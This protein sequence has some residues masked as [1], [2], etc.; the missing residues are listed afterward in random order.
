VPVA[1][2]P[3]PAAPALGTSFGECK[4]QFGNQTW[5]KL[6]LFSGQSY[7]TMKPLGEKKWPLLVS[8]SAAQAARNGKDHNTLVKNVFEQLK[9]MQ[10]P[11]SKAVCKTMILQLLG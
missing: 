4:F 9:A 11:P 3:A 1:V 10:E 6:G 2:P 8:C 5:I 7:I